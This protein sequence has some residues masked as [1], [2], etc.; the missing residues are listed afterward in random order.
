M[1]PARDL[2][3][4]RQELSVTQTRDQPVSTLQPEVGEHGL[5]DVLLQTLGGKASA[6]LNWMTCLKTLRREVVCR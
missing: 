2:P 4:H 6:S 5:A 3:L 1:L